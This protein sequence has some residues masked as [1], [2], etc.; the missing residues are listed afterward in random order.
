MSPYNCVHLHRLRNTVICNGHAVNTKGAE[1]P[2]AGHTPHLTGADES[3]VL[4]FLDSSSQS[5]D[6]VI[7][8]LP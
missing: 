6:S 2:S 4:V 8:G 5:V 3:D 7:L 1:T